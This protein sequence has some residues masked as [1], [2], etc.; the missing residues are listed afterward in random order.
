MAKSTMYTFLMVGS[1]TGTL[2]YAKVC[3]IIDYSDIE[4]VPNEIDATTL[5]HS[6]QVS[7][8]GTKQGSTITCTAPYD[9]TTFSTLRGYEGT[10]KDFA[11]WN[12]ATVSGSTVTPDGSEGKWSF[13]AYLTV[14]KAGGSVDA[15]DAMNIT[16]NVTTEVDFATT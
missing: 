1:G 2:T 4:G 11:I 15:L 14:S 10:E 3:D 8:P 16:L 7:V 9:K 6:R 5:S 12:G 13:K